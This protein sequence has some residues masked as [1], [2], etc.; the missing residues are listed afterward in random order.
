[1]AKQ[2]LFTAPFTGASLQK[3]IDF[4]GLSREVFANY[5]GK[6]NRSW[7]NQQALIKNSLTFAN[8]SRAVIGYARYRYDK[9]NE[10]FVMDDEY[11]TQAKAQLLDQLMA[12]IDEIVDVQQHSHTIKNLQKDK[13][14]VF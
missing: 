2:N 8:T 14:P 3:V 12:E 1:M 13:T 11:K 4:L 9:L 5:A 6:T 7:A 10:N